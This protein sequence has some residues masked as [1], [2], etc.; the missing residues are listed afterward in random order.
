M[1]EP[2][3]L[4]LG[5]D[6]GGEGKSQGEFGWSICSTSNGTLQPPL[7]TGSAKNAWDAL[8]Q[9]KDALRRHYPT[10]HPPVL[11]AGIDAPLFWNPQ[12]KRT[13]DCY[14]KQVLK[15]SGMD[16]SVMHINSLRGACL[17]QGLLLGRHLRETW[18][19]PMTEA[20]PTVLRHLLHRSGQSETTQM[21]EHVIVGLAGHQRDATLSA[22]AAWAMLHEPPRWHN[23]YP[24]EHCP[25]QLIDP[26]ISYWMPLS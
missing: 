14:L 13:V 17:A 24:K 18:D 25:V 11:A 23:L 21:V 5:F 7:K 15:P 20:H 1:T 2:H 19:F 22:V 4:I 16:K 26:P 3:G 9:I 12:G 8:L 10:R 6:P